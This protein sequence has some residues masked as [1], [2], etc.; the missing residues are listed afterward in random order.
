MLTSRDLY[1]YSAFGVLYRISFQLLYNR[2]KQRYKQI[3][4]L[5]PVWNYWS[6][7][8]RCAPF[9]TWQNV[10]KVVSL[11]LFS[12]KDDSCKKLTT[13]A[14]NNMAGKPTATSG[15]QQRGWSNTNEGDKKLTSNGVGYA[16]GLLPSA[17]S[18]VIYL[19]GL[20]IQWFARA[21]YPL[22]TVNHLEKSRRFELCGPV[23]ADARISPSS[24]EISRSVQ[25]HAYR[26]GKMCRFLRKCH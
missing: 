17:T 14:C 3:V 11:L 15:D 12:A 8:A 22:Q 6:N 20:H 5:N 1:V 16:F 10:N 23:A 7:C 19:Y 4:T 9:V 25:L 24:Y 26:P 21:V 2:R 13:T 18:C